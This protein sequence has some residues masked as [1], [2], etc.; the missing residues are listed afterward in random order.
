MVYKTGS[1]FSAYGNQKIDAKVLGSVF[2]IIVNVWFRVLYFTK[3]LLST[4]T[5][6]NRRFFDL[7]TLKLLL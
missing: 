2:V 4:Q 7:N 1:M 6:K 3:Q 5:K